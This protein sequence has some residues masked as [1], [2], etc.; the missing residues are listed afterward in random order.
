M[1]DGRHRCAPTRSVEPA[2]R[3]GRPEKKMPTGVVKSYRGDRG[4]GFIKPDAGGA[5]VFVHIHRCDDGVA[6]LEIGQRV[7]FEE[8][9]S[10]HSEKP[11]AYAVALLTE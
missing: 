3:V 7:R 2:P 1:C 10:K 6:G 4:F 11:E 8:R 9:V 5:D